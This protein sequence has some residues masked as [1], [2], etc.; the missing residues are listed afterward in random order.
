MSGATRIRA[1]AWYVERVV[2][3]VD[4]DQFIVAVELARRPGLRGRPVLVGGDGDP[5]RRGVVAGAS[6]EAREYGVRSGTPLRTAAARCPQAV[7]LPL[8]RDAYLAASAEFIAALREIPG[9]LEVAG[10]DE[11]FVLVDTGDAEQ[12]ARSVQAL[13]R[14]RTGLACS[15]GIGDNRLRAKLGAG[16]AKPAGVFRLGSANWWAVMAERTPEALWGVGRKTSARLAALG[17]R[18]VRD[19]AEADVGWLAGIFGPR[20][21]PWLATLARGEAATAVRADPPA[22]RSRGREFTFQQDQTDLGALRS[23]VRRLARQV[24]GDLGGMGVLAR[25]VVVK[26]RQ[27]P[28]STR[29]HG[30]RLGSPTRDPSVIEEAALAAFDDFELRRPVRLVGVR[31]EVGRSAADLTAG[32]REGHRH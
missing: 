17:V 32:P 15:V 2:L 5:M 12:T 23:E 27:A 6:Y 11:A 1:Q 3:H 18:S 9:T 8:D 28:F 10:W 19:L 7:F 4:L 13:V 30:V 29:T 22:A 20:T 14:G 31:A 24:A 21:G 26:L 25:R 16:F